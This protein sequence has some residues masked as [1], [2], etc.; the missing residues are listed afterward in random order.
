[1]PW[2]QIEHLANKPMAPA[3]RLDDTAQAPVKEQVAASH[4]VHSLLTGIREVRCEA[5]SSCRT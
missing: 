4:L 1:M 3:S 5:L 2:K